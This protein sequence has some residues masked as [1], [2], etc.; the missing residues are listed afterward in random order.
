MQPERWRQIEALYDQACS[1]GGEERRAFIQKA[2]AHDASLR[3][4]LESLLASGD[5]AKSFI[6]TPAMD[7]AA[8]EMAEMEGETKLHQKED[9]WAGRMVSHYRVQEN[10]GI[11]GMSVVY[12]AEDTRLGGFVALKFLPE[13]SAKDPQAL[14][15][16]RRE[17]RVLRALNHLNICVIHDIDE[18]AG[19]P[20]IVMEYLEGQTLKEHLAGNF[21]K[22][23][24]VLDLAIQIADALDAAHAKGIVHRDIKPRNIIVTSRGQ[25]KILDFGLAKLTLLTVKFASAVG[26]ESLTR[27]GMLLGTVEYMSPEQVLAKA[28]DA[29]SDRFSIGLVLYE[30]TTGRRPFAGESV[31]MIFDAILHAAPVPPLSLNAELPP[32]LERIILKALEK[33]PALRYQ[34][35]AELKADLCR[36][37]GDRSGPDPRPRP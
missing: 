5:E 17:A 25:A 21:L 14:E 7:H 20:F 32:E 24:E 30:M 26:E 11:G 35:A 34:T 31:G 9:A 8:R 27:T 22:T 18:Y 6:E 28:V 19:Q 37:G 13:E 1:L 3:E 12:M 4:E 29:R 10:L 16:F 23:D 15:R 36:A 2:C 33:D